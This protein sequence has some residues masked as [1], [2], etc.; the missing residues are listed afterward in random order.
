MTGPTI[1]KK[2]VPVQPGKVVIGYVH[3]GQVSAF[4]AHS[5][6]VTVA[7]DMGAARRIVGVEQEWSSANISDSRNAVVRRFLND[8]DADWLWFIDADMA[9]D[10]N[11]LEGL[12]AKCDAQSAPIVGGLCFGSSNGELFPTLYHLAEVDGEVTTVRVHEYTDNALNQVAATG[13][14][15]LMIHRSVLVA[16]AE[17]EFNSVFP[18]FQE[19]HLGSRPVGEDITFCLRAG[20]LG[21]SVFVNAGVKVGHHKSNLL[22]AELHAE[23]RA[24]LEGT[25]NA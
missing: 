16:M 15:F 17:R 22:T 21:F 11:A 7:A 10:N 5:L 20:Q 2:R 14:A 23:Q 3:P 6:V 4:F 12:M 24:A 9:W 18:W 8:Y 19:T 25:T 1:G 13:A